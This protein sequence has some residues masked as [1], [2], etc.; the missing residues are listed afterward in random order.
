[1][2]HLNFRGKCYKCN[3]PTSSC[4]CDHV[5]K[6]ETNTQFI[7]LMHPKEHKKTKNGT[8]YLTHQ[9]LPNSKVFIGIDFSKNKIINDILNDKNNICFILYPGD[10][11]INLSHEKLNSN[12][13]NIVI[14]I[15]DSTWACSK[16]ILRESTNL[17]DLFK[18]S[19]DNTTL[20]QFKIK[21][22]PNA[23]CL[24]TI[25]STLRVITLLSE[26]N[27]EKVEK[28]QLALFLNPFNKMVEYQINS[29]KNKDI[30][31]KWMKSS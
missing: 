21:T 10:D 11:S 2:N 3:R 25:E 31:K 13:K 1:M 7:I 20:S 30:R 8:G 28:A 6:I 4:M 23:Y 24:S 27:L 19:F 5:K 26:Q 18:V 22:Q 9:S 17:S 15:I 12:N 29:A 16:K 14:F